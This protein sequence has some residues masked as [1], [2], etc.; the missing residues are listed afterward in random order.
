M[1]QVPT[2]SWLFIFI[3]AILTYIAAFWWYFTTD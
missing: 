2:S 1:E 3:P